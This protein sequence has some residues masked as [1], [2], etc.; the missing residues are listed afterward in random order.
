MNLFHYRYSIFFDLWIGDSFEHSMNN[1]RGKWELQ[2]I[3]LLGEMRTCVENVHRTTRNKFSKL[4]APPRKGLLGGE[5]DLT[6]D[7]AIFHLNIC[8]Y[9][10][11]LQSSVP[12]SVVISMDDVVILN[13]FQ[14]MQYYGALSSN[15]DPWISIIEQNHKK[16]S[17]TIIEHTCSNLRHF[18]WLNWGEI[19]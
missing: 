4:S 15:W 7:L 14:G 9:N 10:Q 11:S 6:I 19:E 16:S 8:N 3:P 12:L 17:Q 2:N 18:V 1:L 5:G 13:S